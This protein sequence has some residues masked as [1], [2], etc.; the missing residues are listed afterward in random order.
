MDRLVNKA[1]G[2]R[3]EATIQSDVRL[4]LLDDELGLDEDDLMD[5]HLEAQ[6]R[7]PLSWHD[8]S[9]LWMRMTATS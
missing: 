2:V 6:A 4:L 5:V 1:G 8:M 3:S 9:H 7:S